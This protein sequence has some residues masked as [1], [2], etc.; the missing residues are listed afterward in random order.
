V[1]KR[2]NARRPPLVQPGLVGAFV[3]HAHQLWCAPHHRNI[4]FIVGAPKQ[5]ADVLQ[6]VDMF[7]FAVAPSEESLFESLRGANVSGAGRCGQ[8]QHARLRFH[9]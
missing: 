5:S 3:E 2:S 6:G 4:S 7:H 8:Q 9:L 1:F